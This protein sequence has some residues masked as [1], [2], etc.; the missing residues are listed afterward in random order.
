MYFIKINARSIFDPE[1]GINSDGYMAIYKKSTTNISQLYGYSLDMWEKLG[2]EKP[3]GWEMN[4]DQS[5]KIGIIENEKLKILFNDAE[6][7]HDDVDDSF[8][9]KDKET[10]HYILEKIH[11]EEFFDPESEFEEYTVYH[12]DTELSTLIACDK[13]EE[14]KHYHP[15]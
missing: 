4:Y 7:D 11:D 12:D 2:K 15:E 13:Y 5:T 3:K 10:G 6:Y 14:A 9:S 1:Y 8:I